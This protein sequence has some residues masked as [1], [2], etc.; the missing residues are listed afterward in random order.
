MQKPELKNVFTTLKNNSH[1][2]NCPSCGEKGFVIGTSF[3]EDV[4]RCMACELCFLRKS[5]RSNTDN[6]NHWYEELIDCDQSL[7]DRFVTDMEKPYVAQ[8]NILERLSPG[9]ELLDIGCGLGIFL[10]IAK[11]KQ[12]KVH[13]IESSEHA[14]QFAKKHFNIKYKQNLEELS[15]L[16][17]D[18]IRLSHVLEHIPEP[19][20]ILTNIHRLLKSQGI[21]VIIVP[22]REPLSATVVNWIRRIF[23]QKPKLTG[24]IY[25]DMHVLGFSPS[26]LS[27][28]ITP[29]GFDSI[30]ISTISMGNPIYFPM[31][32]DGLLSRKSIRNI[33]IK[34]LFMYYL[35]MFF[36]NLGNRF[37]KGQW[38]VGYFRKK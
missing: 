37:G 12:W 23:S 1:E 26:S 27:N 9:R 6:D 19:K 14:V 25:P 28:L 4:L 32:Y 34:T 17:I 24:A 22:N 35:P 31:F 21:L 16:G 15:Q 10:S 33:P 11:E 29:F 7:V 2:D 8:L 38:I 5:I 13:G 36:D 20:D 30:K 18:V 3:S